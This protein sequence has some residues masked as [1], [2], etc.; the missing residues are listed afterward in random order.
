MQKGA[1]AAVDAWTIPAGI[2]S[3]TQLFRQTIAV[4]VE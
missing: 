4:S 3:G 1:K 2:T